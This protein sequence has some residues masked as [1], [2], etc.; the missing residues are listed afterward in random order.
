M[1][2]AL[3][4]AYDRAIQVHLPKDEVTGVTIGRKFKDGQW[5]HEQ[6]VSTESRNGRGF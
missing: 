3:Q 4:K 6:C 5:T 2:E 1:N